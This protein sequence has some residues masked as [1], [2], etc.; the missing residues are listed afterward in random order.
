MDTPPPQVRQDLGT[1]R[2]R[3]SSYSSPGV[4]SRPVPGSVP[5][6]VGPLHPQLLQNQR[7]GAA[8][9]W[10]TAPLRPPPPIMDASPC[11]RF[12]RVPFP[13]LAA[14]AARR[15]SRARRT[16]LPPAG[17]LCGQVHLT[18]LIDLT[19]RLKGSRGGDA[20]GSTGET[21]ANWQHVSSL[22]PSSRASG[23]WSTRRAS[24]LSPEE[25]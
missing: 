1:Q 17:P 7:G 9:A 10:E 12:P 24:L 4:T 23:T 13:V 15:G 8:A 3:P 20:A 16:Q 25:L 21:R 5:P 18:R 6:A 22:C 11:P 14:Q 2:E 19:Q